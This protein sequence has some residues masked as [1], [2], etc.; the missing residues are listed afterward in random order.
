MW[1]E[2]KHPRDNSGKFT[3]SRGVQ[4]TRSNSYV[5]LKK[6]SKQF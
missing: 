5:G 1:D 6:N 2:D 4:G 3:D